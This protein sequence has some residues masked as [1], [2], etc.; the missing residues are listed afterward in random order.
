MIPPELAA[1]RVG[2]GFL[3]GLPLGLLADFL[4]PLRPRHTNLADTLLVLAAGWVLL[5]FGFGI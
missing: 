2:I 4:H 3:L 1:Q 5:F